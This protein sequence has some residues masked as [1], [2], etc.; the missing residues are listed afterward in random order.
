MGAGGRVGAARRLAALC[1]GLLIAFGAG[2]Q[3]YDPELLRRRQ[4]PLASDAGVAALPVPSWPEALDAGVSE[5]PSES[6]AL[7]QTSIEP[8][9]PV[10]GPVPSPSGGCEP[11]GCASLICDAPFLDCDGRLDNG[12][13]VDG[14]SDASHCGACGN[15]CG[16]LAHTELV[17]C[18]GS[19]EPVQCEPGFAS[20]DGQAATGCETSIRTLDN[21]GGCQSEG[22]SA[23]CDGLPHVQ[24]SACATEACEIEQCDGGWANCDGRVDN[25]CERDQAAFGPCDLSL[26]RLRIDPAF[27]DEPLSDFPVLVRLSGDAALMTARADGG[28]LLFSLAADPESGASALSFE[29]EAWNRAAGELVAWVRMPSVSDSEPTV[30]YL[31]FGDGV[32]RAG[33][34]TP[35]DVWRA[36]FESVHHFGEGFGEATGRPIAADNHGSTFDADGHIGGARAFFDNA[37]V[38]LTGGVLPAA[39]D[40][41]LTAWVKPVL[42]EGNTVKYVVDT[43][44]IRVPFIGMALGVHQTSGALS[45]YVNGAFRNS[46]RDFARDG[47]W[48]MVAARYH[49]AAS[50]G[51]F[52]TSVDGRPFEAVFSGNTEDARTLPSSPFEVGRWAGGTYHFDGSIDELQVASTARSDAWL[53]ASY[54]NQR[55]GST[56]LAIEN[57]PAP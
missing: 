16:A 39:D 26:K 53:Y 8:D 31:H 42:A 23:A 14:A 28:D 25:G 12:C 45:A 4:L 10:G 9:L 6:L 38:S 48:H 44:G 3:V 2:C 43:S 41:T 36:Q 57:L 21:C 34:V 46:R 5:H 17:A 11:D 1:A 49:I 20:C 37:Y 55:S 47:E 29:L 32:D 18:D 51:R 50:G 24:A 30:F 15:D 19:C 40:Y 22:K 7:V 56:F 54:E 27:V 35:S 52:E 13:E 33:A